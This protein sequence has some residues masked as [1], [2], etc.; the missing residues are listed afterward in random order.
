[1]GFTLQGIM[2]F[3]ICMISSIIICTR[4]EKI[5]N[6]GVYFFVIG[7]VTCYFDLLTH[8]IITLGFPMTNISIIK[9]RK[10]TNVIKRSN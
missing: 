10:R 6:I 3:I 7:M 4:F 1:M 8:P 5:K 9:T 2:T